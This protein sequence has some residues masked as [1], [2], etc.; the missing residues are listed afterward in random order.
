MARTELAFD[1]CY[2]LRVFGVPRKHIKNNSNKNIHKSV[3]YFVLG[4]E[5]WHFQICGDFLRGVIFDEFL[6]QKKVTPNPKIG[7]TRLPRGAGSRRGGPAYWR[8][9]PKSPGSPGDPWAQ[10][11]RSGPEG[12]RGV[13]KGRVCLSLLSLSL[14]SS[15]NSSL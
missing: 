11:I 14:L 4:A 1:T 15:L 7:I 3:K 6:I 2:D 8:P 9:G 13:L 10:Y 12:A 5:G